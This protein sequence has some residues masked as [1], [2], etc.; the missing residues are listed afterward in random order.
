MKL[1]KEKLLA[2][3][4]ASRSVLKTSSFRDAAHIIF[5]SCKNFI[6]ASSGYVALLSAD[7]KYNELIILDSG[8]F[9]NAASSKPIMPICGLQ[10]IANQMKKPIFENDFL[11]SKLV[12]DIPK[13]HIKLKNIL[14][15]PLI[16]EGKIVGSIGLANKPG[17]FNEEDLGAISIFTEIAVIALN[18]SY[19][20]NSLEKSKEQYRNIFENMH[21]GVIIYE[22]V[23]N[24][25]DFKIVNVNKAREIISKVTKEEAIGKLVIEIFPRIK[26][27]GLFDVLKRVWKTG[28]PEHLPISRY[29]EEKLQYWS[30][31]F[32]YKLSSGE[33]VAVYNN[34]TDRKIAEQVLKESEKKFREDF[35]ASEFY[36][37]L[38]S[39]DI[40]NILQIIL[41]N[42]EFGFS[43]LNNIEE[44]KV[45][46]NKI[47][48]NVERAKELINNVH[49]ISQIVDSDTKLEKIE[50][51]EVFKRAL[52]FIKEQIKN[53]DVKIKIDAKNMKYF[54]FANEFLQEVFDNVLQNSI[55]HNKS[56]KIEILIRFRIEQINENR[57]IKIEFI[58]NGIG[59][60]DDK[61]EKIF[62]RFYKKDK[63]VSGV[64]LGLSVVRKII[65]SYNGKIWVQDRVKGNYSKGSNF[66]ILIPE[67]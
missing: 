15:A 54:I 23:D 34:I 42:A 24:G 64:G 33:L 52:N 29:K 41:L 21:R 35:N 53:K 59:I 26:K 66:T 32:V 50:I 8:E 13:G 3:L 60:P 2:I 38:L 10:A 46:L 48:R 28:V 65:D 51:C 1:E 27:N 40:R 62:E 17:R 14:F 58:D 37:D 20:L 49:K 7:G 19:L 18:N 9:Q 12:K 44:M 67:A 56:K 47:I 25:R 57:F 4:T 61:K 22:A 36:K 5:D 63:D 55:K 30:E 43:N 6:K 31:N 45:I 39:H 11:N 16:L